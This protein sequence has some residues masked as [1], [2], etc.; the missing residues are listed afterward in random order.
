MRAV[1]E[2]VSI[3]EYLS[4]PLYAR[5]EW[6]EGEIV[7]RGFGTGFHGHLT[8]ELSAHIC[9]YFLHHPIGDVGISVHCHYVLAGERIYRI[10]DVALVLGQRMR[11]IHHI[12]GAP[13][14]AFEVR[15]PDESVTS[16]IAKCREYIDAGSLF[17]V[18]LVPE[19]QIVHVMTARQPRLELGVGDT[20]RFP[21]VLPGFELPLKEL[22]A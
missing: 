17:A 8:G 20:L 12:D 14:I 21:E 10:P 3:D 15:S 5:S 1:G 16:Q 2:L 4:N 22:F 19:K 6:V 11:N 18:L 9:Q 13:A 7:E